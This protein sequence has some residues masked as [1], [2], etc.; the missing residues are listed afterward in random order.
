MTEKVKPMSNKDIAV[1]QTIAGLD[2]VVKDLML[3]REALAATLPK[4]E[5]RCGDATSMPSL[6]QIRK[7]KKR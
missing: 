3:Q 2:R 4:E 6:A 5:R 7:G 1:R